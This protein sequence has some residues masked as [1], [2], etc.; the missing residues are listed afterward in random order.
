MKRE[1]LVLEAVTDAGSRGIKGR[2]LVDESYGVLKLSTIYVYLDRLEAKGL[3]RVNDDGPRP[4]FFAT[5]AGREL[6]NQQW[7]A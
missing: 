7:R 5:N 3:I 6:V 2:R 1:R 4:V